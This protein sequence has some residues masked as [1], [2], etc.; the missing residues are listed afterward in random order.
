[1]DDG[2]LLDMA[3]AQHGL[4]S[5]EQ[6][7][8]L[9]IS[10]YS[11]RRL[12]TNGGW[13]PLTKR[14]L[15][16]SGSP[17]TA[18]QQVLAAV[19]DAGPGSA[20]SHGSSAALWG[21]AGFLLLP[22]VVARVMSRSSTRLATVH[23]VRA[24]PERW[25]TTL[26]AI[27]VVRP[28]LCILQLCATVHPGRAE[29]ALDTAWS[30]RLLSGGSLIELLVDLGER[31]RNGVALLRQLVDAR[32]PD[33]IPPASNLE[34]RLDRILADAGLPAMRRQID[35]GSTTWTGRVDFRCSDLPLIVEVQSERYHSALV[36][37][38]ADA[39]RIR[40]LERD[41][42]EVIE[43][44]DVD[45]WQRPAAVV[46]RIRAARHELRSQSSASVC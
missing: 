28:E 34:G 22:A 17:V 43:V 4:V 38:L 20:L 41:G 33:Y 40:Q 10:S 2:E 44:T 31:G 42:F 12:I 5:R 1:M 30:M 19:F 37:V 11:R 23:S 14:V 25:V 29:R 36:D 45:V 21:L 9:G 3:A 39:K 8:D 35:S 15:R 16:R 7:L 26:D 13:V 24:L 27:P 46:A 32:G 6:L 18:R